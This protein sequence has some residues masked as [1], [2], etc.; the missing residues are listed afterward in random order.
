MDEIRKRAK[1]LL[2]NQT[3]K[4]VIGYGEGTAGKTRAVFIRKPED[5]GQLIFDDRCEQNL[6]VYLL[7][8][9]VK[10]LGKLAIIATIP[11]MRTILQVASELQL[12]ENDV[13]ILG[14]TPEKNLIELEG[15]K[16]VEDYLKT[17]D[18]GIRKEDKELLTK[19]TSLSLEEKWAYWEEELSRCIKCYA[20]RAACPMCYCLRCF[21]EVNQ[22]QWIPIAPNDLGNM[23]WHL[24]RA[25]H[26]AGRCINCGE[27]GRACPVDI[28]IH[29]LTFKGVEDVHT[30]FNVVAGMNAT[31]ESV[32][33]SFKPD[34]KETFIR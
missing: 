6:A 14:I 20:C 2:E 16:S 13:V 22:P 10:H 26:L 9:E 28:P 18:V 31:M 34:D 25:M 21:V 11:V 4:V 1:E 12:T 8:H 3:A 32:L 17:Q 24:L 29:L 23:E 7:K 5:T 19:L 33:S 27:C 30:D 15:F